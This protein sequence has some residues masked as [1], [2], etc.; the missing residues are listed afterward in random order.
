MYINMY[1][2]FVIVFVHIYYIQMASI[3][4]NLTLV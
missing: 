1:C 2:L 4:S 3:R